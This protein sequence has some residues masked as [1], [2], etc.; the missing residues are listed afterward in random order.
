MMMHLGIGFLSS[1]R[2][3]LGSPREEIPSHLKPS[4]IFRADG[5]RP[6]GVSIVP[7]MSDLGMHAMSDVGLKLRRVW[8]TRRQWGNTCVSYLTQSSSGILFNLSRFHPPK[9]SQ[10]LMYCPLV[11]LRVSH[12]PKQGLLLP[13]TC[14]RLCYL[15]SST[16]TLLSV[17]LWGLPV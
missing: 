4:D 12:S 9:Q 7:W 2:G 13:P 17:L 3:A 14:F 16:R 8:R 10:P 15:Y 5:K 1:A 6:D 11:P